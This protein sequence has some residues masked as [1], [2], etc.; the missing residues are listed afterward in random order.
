ML[1]KITIVDIDTKEVKETHYILT[2]SVNRA[3]NMFD[4]NEFTDVIAHILDEEEERQYYAKKFGV[5]GGTSTSKVKNKRMIFGRNF[6]AQ[7]LK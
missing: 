6:L 2:N 4:D 3:L 7:Q 1:I 5:V